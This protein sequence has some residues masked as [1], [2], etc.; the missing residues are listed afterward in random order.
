[1]GKIEGSRCLT[2]TTLNNPT[3]AWCQT[4]HPLFWFANSITVTRP[5]GIWGAGAL[6]VEVALYLAI[7]LGRVYRVSS[8]VYYSLVAVQ[9]RVQSVCFYKL[10]DH[11]SNWLSQS[12][13]SQSHGPTRSHCLRLSRHTDGPAGSLSNLKPPPLPSRTGTLTHTRQE[14]SKPGMAAANL[15]ALGRRTQGL[16]FVLK[17]TAT[18]EL[19]SW[20]GS[21]HPRTMYA[22]VLSLPPLSH[23]AKDMI[24]GA[25]DSGSA[26]LTPRLMAFKTSWWQW[27]AG[28]WLGAGSMANL[29]WC[30]CQWI[31]I[32]ISF[33]VS[34]LCGVGLVRPRMEKP[35][36]KRHELFFQG[37]VIIQ[38]ATELTIP[39]MNSLRL[40]VQ[41]S[42]SYA[43]L[44][45]W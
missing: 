21:C 25:Q 5:P 1:M 28:C 9:F 22:S 45:R 16:D 37:I 15:K 23:R 29:T 19:S 6:R 12:K 34:Q 43:T 41:T 38:V 32:M 44:S 40:L 11:C 30:S 20:S 31:I 17:L 10:T 35:H 36:S 2:V 18:P 4:S 27:L 14:T 26:C 39:W 33:K 13:R 24:P 8:L 3:P 7:F 42:L